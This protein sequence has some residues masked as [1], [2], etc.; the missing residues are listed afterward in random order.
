MTLE[1][2]KYLSIKQAAFVLDWKQARL[3]YHVNKEN[4]SIPY[5]IQGGHKLFD[6]TE[7]LNWRDTRKDGRKDRYKKS[8]KE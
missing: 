2:N 3:Q 6:L 1:N 7:L 5:T 4:T 8:T